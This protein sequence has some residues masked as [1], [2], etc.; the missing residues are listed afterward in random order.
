MDHENQSRH[1]RNSV[2]HYIYQRK[3]KE[4]LNQEKAHNNRTMSKQ[5][6]SFA[7]LQ[8]LLKEFNYILD[9]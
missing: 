7:L 2:H 4:K 5:N 6:P 1:V 3:R 9:L 8:K